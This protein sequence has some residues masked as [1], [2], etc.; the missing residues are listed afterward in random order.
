MDLSYVAGFFDAEGNINILLD[1]RANRIGIQARIYNSNEQILKQ[2][3]EFIHFG[4]IFKKVRITPKGDKSI[5][6]ELTIGNKQEC[7]DFLRSI[8]PHSILKKQQL[9]YLFNNFNFNSQQS[10]K[11]F[12]KIEFDKLKIRLNKT[13]SL[14]RG[15]PDI[16]NEQFLTS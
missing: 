1:K 6:F 9:D 2:I 7:L 5:V 4:N 13:S 14:K 16:P 10:N 11:N 8:Y 15:I 3:K 12:N